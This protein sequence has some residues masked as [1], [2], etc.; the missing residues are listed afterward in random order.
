M[1]RRRKISSKYSEK[2][3]LPDW[4]SP[5][6][7]EK[8]FESNSRR[9]LPLKKTKP[10]IEH[11]IAFVNDNTSPA[12]IERRFRQLDYYQKKGKSTEEAA[13]LVFANNLMPQ[14]C[15]DIS[16]WY[17]AHTDSSNS[18]D[19]EEFNAISD[20]GDPLI[21]KEESPNKIKRKISVLSNIYPIERL[22]G[23]IERW[24][25]NKACS[26]KDIPAEK[27]PFMFNSEQF[28]YGLYINKD[29]NFSPGC[30]TYH[31]LDEITHK[32]LI[33]PE[34]VDGFVFDPPIG[35]NGYTMENFALL[36]EN[37]FK[38][39]VI[40]KDPN[41]CPLILIWCDHDTVS[42]IL[43]IADDNDLIHCDSVVVELYNSSMEPILIKTRAGLNQSSRM[44]IIFKPF[45]MER[46]MIAQQRARDTDWGLVY[47]NGK[48]RNRLGMPCT[49]HDILDLTLPPKDRPRVFVEFWPSRFGLRDNWIYYDEN[50]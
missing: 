43:R 23:L 2:D 20:F 26:E 33:L 41:N 37:I 7:I 4:T 18:S 50:L 13:Q 40:E 42:D 44:I 30:Y 24:P 3:F 22:G 28:L 6:E 46:N 39:R 15:P 12:E 21:K 1:R 45:H 36:V 9:V 38:P 5:A 8:I 11:Y 14:D 32:G 16:L 27:H 19:D 31:L 47:K 25:I 48:S 10:N 35:Y 17:N 34:K 49:P 29:S